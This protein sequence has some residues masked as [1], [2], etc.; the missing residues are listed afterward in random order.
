MSL[1]P[2]I[3]EMNALTPATLDDLWAEA[4][5]LGILRIRTKTELYDWAGI[6]DEWAAGLAAKD[7][8]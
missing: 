3:I 7:K 2:K 8:T 6:V 4:E 1:I 5:T